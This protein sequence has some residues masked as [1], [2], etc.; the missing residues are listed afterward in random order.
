MARFYSIG[1]L[2]KKNP[3]WYREDLEILMK[4][5]DNKSIH[6]IIDKHF[7]LDQV[8]EAHRMIENAKSTGKIIFDISS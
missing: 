4:M 8:V 6:P 2:R 1:G 3:Q 7:T 5:L